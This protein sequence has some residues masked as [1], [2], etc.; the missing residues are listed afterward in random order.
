MFGYGK[1]DGSFHTWKAKSASRPDDPEYW[2][3]DSMFN[4]WKF[5]YAKR[6]PREK[7]TY[8]K[9]TPGEESMFNN[10]NRGFNAD[11]D[12]FRKKG[13]ASEWAAW[14]YNPF[15]IRNYRWHQVNNDFENSYYSALNDFDSQTHES[16]T[17]EPMKNKDFVKRI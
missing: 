14:K 12:M 6:K 9:Y 2:D 15:R 4:K 1:H 16:M 10:Q 5:G 7:K 8:K 11:E 17:R 13:N 3:G